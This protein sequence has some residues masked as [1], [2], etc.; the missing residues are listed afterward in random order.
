MKEKIESTIKQI[1]DLVA[2]I[3]QT[4]N[5]GVVDGFDE[6]YCPQ[7]LFPKAKYFEEFK[8]NVSVLSQNRIRC[9]ED[10][11]SEYQSAKTLSV[12]QVVKIVYMF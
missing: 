9:E 11:K 5:S 6:K 10:L 3:E 7:L 12:P 1:A 4:Y 8:C 2:K